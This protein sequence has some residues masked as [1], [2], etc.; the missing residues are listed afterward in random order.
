VLLIVEV[1]VVAAL[2]TWLTGFSL[3]WSEEGG[4]PF[5]WKTSNIV[6]AAIGCPPL[7]TIYDW[8]AFMLDVLFYSALGYC[9]LLIL[10]KYVAK[11]AASRGGATFGQLP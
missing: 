5:V 11:K 9:F 7:V 10:F 4:F 2:A 1:P 6:C 3:S 8:T